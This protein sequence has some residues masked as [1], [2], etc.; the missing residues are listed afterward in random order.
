MLKIGIIREGKV[1]P[2]ARTPMT[3]EQ[4]AE[5]QVE[6]P[7]RIV[8]QPSQVRCF[9]DAEYTN[10]GIH[11]QEDLSDCNLLLGIKEVPIN[12]LL[13]D[14]AYMFFSH[15]MKK[16]AYNR[17][18]L[19]ALVDKNIRMIDYEALQDEKGQRLIAFGFYAGIVG[20]HNALWTW[21]E[22]TGDFSL[23]RLSNSHD[24][25]QVLEVYNQM[26]LP[27]LRIV[28]T[29][30]GRVAKGAA[31][32][33]KDMGIGQVSPEEYLN[34]K[35]NEPVFTQ[36]KASDYVER[37]D[38]TA[39]DKAD[40]YANGAAYQSKFHLFSGITDIFIN[41]I[42]YDKTAPKFFTLKEINNS[43]FSIQVIADITCDIMPDSSVPCTI[44]ASKIANPVYGIDKKSG[45]ETLPF[46]AGS[47]DIMAIDNL[48][49]E[50]PRDA[51]AFFLR[52][53]IEK[54]LPEFL[55]AEESEVLKQATICGAGAL[56]EKFSYLQSFLI[57]Q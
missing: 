3:P 23:P 41:G 40:F 35:F 19:Q 42:F 11:L 10:H 39:F 6:L 45:Q 8:V 46:E 34:Q 26:N 14:K 53:L 54:I 9:K 22:R 52:Q 21:G 31:K 13:A 27:P 44:R 28:L 30:G 50:L 49:S 38:G 18:L 16:Q 36:L 47:I 33:L 15:T 1:P 2:D 17:P 43:D 24:Y 12:Q 55:L 29:G 48:P 56:T 51:S 5:A 57:G 7:L 32:N 37:K 20:A 4:C 25:A